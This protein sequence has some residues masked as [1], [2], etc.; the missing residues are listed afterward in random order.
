MLVMEGIVKS[1][2][3]VRANDGASLQVEEGS[4]HALVG[5]NGAGKT[6]LMN[7][8]FGL[9]APEAGQILLRGRRIL[10]RHPREAMEAGLGM[11]HQHFTLVPPFT[12]LENVA[13][14]LAGRGLW[15]NLAEVRRRLEALQEEVGLE[16]PLEVPVEALS[17]SLQQRVEILKA[18]YRGARLLILDEPTALLLPQEVESLF[19]ALRRFVA[20]G[21]TVIFITHKL[22][23]VFAYA[24]QVTVLRRGRTV[25]Q[26]RVEEVTPEQVSLWMVGEA[27][28]VERARREPV[29]PGV[30]L[31]IEGLRVEQP[32]GVGLQGVS[33][34]VRV[35]ESFGLAGVAGN[36]QEL[37]LRTL[38]GLERPQG[39]KA[40]LDGRELPLGHP[41]RLRERGIG[42]IPEDRQ[43][44]G[45][46]PSLPLWENF[47]L[48]HQRRLS[49]R[50]G[51]WLRRRA[52]RKWAEELMEA[53]QVR[54][55]GVGMRASHLS[56]GNQQKLVVGRELEGAVTCLLALHPTRGLDWASTA[57]VHQQM[58]A[59]RRRG[60][61][62]LWTSNDLD[63]LLEWSDRIG[64][65]Y[66]GRL[67]VVLEAGK[68]HREELGW[69]MA[70]GSQASVPF[71]S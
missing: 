46:L 18:L 51:L 56:G 20:R 42:Y 60:V 70:G 63:E 26:A 65:F 10:F 13:L 61:S 3:P 34:E 29:S 37:L 43:G 15:L 1:F 38:A 14:G 40:W 48:G 39:G 6:T 50:R 23:E 16:V 49:G 55:Q 64:V 62:L 25:A 52:A 19:Q 68:T 7:I 47:L 30:R 57:F 17:V 4:I 24:D 58:E 33:L 21:G 31:R 71:A 27:W 69:W 5:E 22:P 12:A 11:V 54:G 36:G 45:L 9:L 35:G 67:L 59:A 2:G 41:A 53:Y 44:E 28:R 8:L 66:R 32:G